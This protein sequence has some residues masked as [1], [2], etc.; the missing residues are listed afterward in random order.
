MSGD[1]AVLLAIDFGLTRIGVATGN[2]LTCSA[3]PLETISGS[4]P[5]VW[6][7]L[8]RIVAEWRPDRIVVGMPSDDDDHPLV[9]RIRA[10]VADLGARYGL[11]VHTVDEAHTSAEAMRSLRAGRAG[12]VHRRRVTKD[13]IDRHAACL[14]A[15]RWM[16]EAP[17]DI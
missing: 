16:Q 7:E 2:R 9:A 12:G 6:R 15:E 4:G 11:P 10:F 1:R 8:D 17:D 5:A 13:R 14:I 3:T